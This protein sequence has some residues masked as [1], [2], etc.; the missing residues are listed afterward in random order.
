MK[1][2]TRIENTRI[3]ILDLT[4]RRARIEV[5]KKIL[6]VE[7]KLLRRQISKR[8]LYINKLITEL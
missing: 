4:K 8:H 2:S 7:D 5:E 6:D 3:K 1:P